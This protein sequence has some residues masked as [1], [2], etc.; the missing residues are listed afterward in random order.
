MVLLV[1]IA[2][3]AI[4]AGAVSDATSAPPPVRKTQILLLDVDNT[5]Y[6]EKHHK[7]E[8]QIVQNI[9][10]FVAGNDAGCA[11]DD[12]HLRFGSTIEGL[13]QTAWKNLS[14]EALREKQRDFYQWVY[15]NIDCSSLLQSQLHVRPL[16]RNELDSDDSS[17][18]CI[19]TG[20]SHCNSGDSKDF[21]YNVA[22]QQTAVRRLL[23]SVASSTN[24]QWE[25]HVASNNGI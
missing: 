9:H 20:Y 10:R 1:L 2:S 13:R 18:R 4:V 14:F 7:I 15:S 11:A 21:V 23:K 8:A 3:F 16:Q 19:K 12:L 17:I 25:F 5:L 6:A 22:A 24:G